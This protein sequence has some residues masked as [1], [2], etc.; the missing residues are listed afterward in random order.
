MD[1]R[2]DAGRCIGNVC[3]D[4]VCLESMRLVFQKRSKAVSCPAKNCWLLSNSNMGNCQSQ[5]EYVQYRLFRGSGSGHPH[6]PYPSDHPP[7][8][9]GAGERHHP[10]ARHHLGHLSGGR[11]DGALSAARAGGRA[12]RSDL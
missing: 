9:N 2:S 8:E 6:H 7:G 5:F 1:P 12:G 4:A 3:G 10:D 11:A